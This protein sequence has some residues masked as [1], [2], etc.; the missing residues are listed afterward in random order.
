[1]QLFSS[2]IESNNN[3]E[4]SS[5]SNSEKTWKTPPEIFN[6]QLQSIIKLRLD[7]FDECYLE[8]LNSILCPICKT[9]ILFPLVDQCGHIFCSNCIQSY[10]RNHNNKCPIS[11][12]IITESLISTDFTWQILEKLPTKC[13]CCNLG[14]VWSGK[15]NMLI[16]HILND[17]YYFQISCCPNEGC[18]QIGNYKYIYFHQKNCNFLLVKCECC[19]EKILWNNLIEHQE[20]CKISEVLCKCDVVVKAQCMENH[21]NNDCPFTEVECSYKSM[22]CETKCQ[23]FKMVD[24]HNRNQLTHC[25]LYLKSNEAN[26]ILKKIN[27]TIDHKIARTYLLDNRIKERRIKFMKKIIKR[28]NNKL[29]SQ[30]MQLNTK[31]LISKHSELM[32]LNNNNVLVVGES[33]EHKIAYSELDV[34]KYETFKWT[35]NIITCEGWIGVG[36]CIK[37]FVDKNPMFIFKDEI[38]GQFMNISFFALSSNGTAW[39]ANNFCQNNA[40]LGISFK[41]GSVI[42]MVYSKSNQSLTFSISNDHNFILSRIILENKENSLVPCIILM[43][44]GDKVQL[45]LNE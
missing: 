1:M 8:K 18:S 44:K 12:N 31:D 40:E 36:L 29:K 43:N 20:A 32:L 4:V 17:C 7:L 11:G 24:H 21:I 30:L 16:N 38:I 25:L 5:F 15:V 10:M 19:N 37:E 13:V 22:G 33:R 39:N 14:C 6:A 28:K 23:R 42:K 3:Q 26:K 45:N 34:S 2:N 27:S 9:V 41:T 35:V